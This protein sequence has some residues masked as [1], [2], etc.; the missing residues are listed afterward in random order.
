MAEINYNPDPRE[1]PLTW[2]PS[3]EYGGGVGTQEIYTGAS[4][5]AAPDDP[6]SPAVFY[7]DGGGSIQQWDVASQT[8]V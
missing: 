7:P 3:R 8:W 1:Q 6:T 4:P 5:P 2:T